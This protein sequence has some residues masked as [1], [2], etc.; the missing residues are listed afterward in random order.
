MRERPEFA[1]G[2]LAKGTV[3]GNLIVPGIAPIRS[4][5]GGKLRN[6]L[7]VGIKKDLAQY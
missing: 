1:E 7:N 6:S 3:S 4:S 5:H 2:P